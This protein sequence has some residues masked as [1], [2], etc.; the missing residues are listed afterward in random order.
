MYEDLHYR[1]G[2]IINANGEKVDSINS[3]NELLDFLVNNVYRN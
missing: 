3:T 1:K 2:S